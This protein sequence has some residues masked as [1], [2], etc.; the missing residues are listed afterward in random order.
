M[1][2]GVRLVLQIQW[3][4]PT[5]LFEYHPLPVSDAEETLMIEDTVIGVSDT[6]GLNVD[7]RMG[8]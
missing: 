1:M 5:L 7:K 6:D 4:P 3:N 8:F 2:K